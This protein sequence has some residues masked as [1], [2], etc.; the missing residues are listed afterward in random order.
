MGVTVTAK[1]RYAVVVSGGVPESCVC[2][3]WAVVT[4]WWARHVLKGALGSAW[5]PAAVSATREG[6][7]SGLRRASAAAWLDTAGVSKVQLSWANTAPT[8]LGSLGSAPAS[9]AWASRSTGTSVGE[10]AAG[11]GWAL[12]AVGRE[13][14]ASGLTG[15]TPPG[16]CWEW[17]CGEGRQGEA[18][19]HGEPR[20]LK[21]GRHWYRL[22]V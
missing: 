15:A 7:I 10:P 1:D 19:G 11:D 22:T 8:A 17:P 12:T 6:V 21:P 13:T 20:W 4:T 9:M 14:P 16:T 18:Q 3:T 5:L 2:T